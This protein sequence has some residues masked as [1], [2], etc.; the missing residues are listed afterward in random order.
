MSETLSQGGTLPSTKPLFGVQWDLTPLWE[1][2]AN[3]TFSPD[4]SLLPCHLA[5]LYQASPAVL[6]QL[7]DVHPMGAVSSVSGMLPIHM[8]SAGWVLEPWVAP[9]PPPPTSSSN[10]AEQPPLQPYHHHHE[11]HPSRLK[12]TLTV[13][14][15][16]LPESLRIRSGNHSM[17]P[18]QY[19][20]EAMEEGPMKQECLSL[21]L[22]GDE[23]EDGIEEVTS[24]GPLGHLTELASASP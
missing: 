23:G 24:I 3:A 15:H 9:P 12:E 13:L 5:V 7:L 1:S 6:K 11:R 18:S 22:P 4:N 10:T 19:I 17:T 21:L 20:A 16:A 8:A 14:C 2:M